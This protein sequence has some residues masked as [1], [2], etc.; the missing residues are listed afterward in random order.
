MMEKGIGSTLLGKYSDLVRWFYLEESY[1]APPE[2]DDEENIHGAGHS[3]RVLVLALTICTFANYPPHIMEQAALAAAAHDIGRTHQ[4]L[5]DEHGEKSAR[6]LQS[7]NDVMTKDWNANVTRPVLYAIHFHSLEDD[8]A[9][10]E[11]FTDEKEAADARLVWA[12]LKDADAL[13]RVRLGDLDPQMLR[14]PV[15]PKLVGLAELLL[16]ENLK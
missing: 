15:S 12:V 3:M 8:L 7:L 16:N 13:D 5:D 2:A 9:T 14:L 11:E 1:G 6:K 10:F 4:G